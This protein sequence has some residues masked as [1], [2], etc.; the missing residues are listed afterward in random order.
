[1][2]KKIQLIRE[3]CIAANPEIGTAKC[4]YS[5]QEGHL[6]LP[7]YSEVPGG[8]PNCVKEGKYLPNG[9]TITLADVLLAIPRNKSAKAQAVSMNG[10]FLDFDEDM[11]EY[12]IVGSAWNLRTDDLESQSPETLLF[13]SEL[14]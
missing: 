5:C 8:C 10:D 11:K 1:M 4:P 9:R 6:I 12:K 2:N 13:L 3:K 7:D 14:L